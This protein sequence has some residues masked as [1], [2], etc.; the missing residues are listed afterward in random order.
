MWQ[1][2]FKL[3]GG[4]GSVEMSD[5]LAQTKD[6]S[7]AKWECGKIVNHRKTSGFVLSPTA[8]FSEGSSFTLVNSEGSSFTLVNSVRVKARRLAGKK[9]S[10]IV[11]ETKQIKYKG[12][13]TNCETRTKNL[14]D[15]NI[16]NRKTVN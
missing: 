8:R 7:K 10:P 12:V 5:C 14:L 11:L 2:L 1:D 9:T 3:Q 4:R 13:E 16:E 6:N 15:R